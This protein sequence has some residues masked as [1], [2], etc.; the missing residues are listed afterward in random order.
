[1]LVPLGLVAGVA[2]YAHY[3][4]TVE[5]DRIERETVEEFAAISTAR[6]AAERLRIETTQARHSPRAHT[7]GRAAEAH[8]T[9]VRATRALQKRVND[10]EEHAAAA[11]AA[12]AASKG[13][14]EAVENA[15][16]GV[17]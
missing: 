7:I 6:D 9:L 13:D 10:A 2:L 15:L 1:M 5:Q 8:A 12:R 16:T 14:V 3:G 4:S 17:R 11:K